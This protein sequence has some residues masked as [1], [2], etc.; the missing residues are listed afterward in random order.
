MSSFVLIP[1]AGGDA[2]YWHR[3][4][5]ELEARG[6]TAIPVQL[7]AADDSAGLRRY[8]ET[9]VD[10]VRARDV[11]PG[12]LVLGGQSM[13]A[14]SAALVAEHLP[15]R[16]LALVNGMIPRP[17]ESGGEWWTST[18]QREAMLRHAR[19]IGLDEAA[20]DDPVV[21][22]AHDVPPAV[23]ATGRPPDQSSTPFAEPWPLVAWPSVP[24][25]VIASRE[26]RLFPLEFQR[27]VARERLGIEPVTVEGGHMV[28]LSRP[29]E[30]AERLVACLADA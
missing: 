11:D 23:F 22:Y 25:T 13:C 19:H 18:G 8:A 1:G 6:H 2:W 10:A 4:V 12:E 14:L 28:A 17:G 21:L 5:P 16:H 27:R 3:L 29:V 24:T 20:L 9:V 7:P 26:D 15:V 30:L